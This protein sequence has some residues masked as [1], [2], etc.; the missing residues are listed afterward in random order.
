MVYRRHLPPVFA[1]FRDERRPVWEAHRQRTR[2]LQAAL[3]YAKRGWPVFPCRPRGKEPLTARGFKDATADPASIQLF[4]S[5]WPDANI[6]IATGSASRLLVV[7]VDPRNNGNEQLAALEAR[8]GALPADYLVRTA[9]GG[10][11]FYF[12][13]PAD[14]TVACGVLAKGIDIKCEGGYV[15]APPSIHPSGHRYQF[16][17]NGSVPPSPDWQLEHLRQKAGAQ[18]HSSGGATISV[19]ELRVSDDIKRLIREGKPKGERSEAVFGAIR[20]MVKAGHC[21][22]EIISIMMNQQYGIS[23]KPRENGLAWLKGEVARARAKPDR[24]ADSATQ[25][26]DSASFSGGQSDGPSG[27]RDSA[28]S[29]GSGTHA[30]PTPPSGVF[31]LPNDHYP[32]PGAARRIFGVIAMTR[33]MF[34]RG[35]TVVELIETSHGKEL[36]LVTSTAFRSRLDNY[37]Y[38]V[39]AYVAV[40][41]G[42]ALRRRRCS[43]DTAKALL[44]TLEAQELLPRIEL[45]AAAPIIVEHDGVPEILGPGYHEQSRVFVIGGEMPYEVPLDEATESLRQLLVDY[46]FQHPGDAARALA[47]LITPALK[48]GRLLHGPTPVDVGEADQ[49]QAGKT[50]R[51]KLIRAIYREHAYPVTMREGGVG[52]LDESISQALLSGKPFVVIDNVRGLISSQFLESVITTPD[53][54]S[55]R[56]PHRGEVSLDARRV[57]FQLSSNGVE[58]TPDFAN[59]SSIVR[60]RKRPKGYQYREHTEG[61]LLSHLIANQSYYL[62]CI[63]AVAAEW[64][65][66]GKPR[67]AESRHDFREWAQALDWIVQNLFGAAALLDGHE[68][69]QERVSNPALSWLRQ[70]CLAANQAGK[71]GQDLSATDIFELCADECVE[72]PRRTGNGMR[73]DEGCKLVG[74]LLAKAFRQADGHL[75]V[76]DDYRVTRHI[77]TEHDEKQR[78]DRETKRYVIECASAPCAP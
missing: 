11:H 77:G 45:V 24:D 60:I 72:F 36:A 50:F 68:Q 40:K 9:D 31:V 73:P 3:S 22:D 74:Q 43:E 25:S 55:A 8:H 47:A 49:S 70:V 38:Q 12:R 39:S 48:V 4:W 27:E 62:G 16:E 61:D 46:D 37:G 33:T 29:D 6:A 66:R 13:L 32:F 10:R 64:I 18:A 14:A 41:N 69:A 57:T 15:I 1:W 75:L 44:A 35:S 7:D 42:I 65:R 19:D 52:S 71:C 2:M 59:R 30:A 53:C 28:R 23:A 51:H 34:V 63:F 78:K 17:R 76:L 58:T 56:V 20:A 26:H 67:T 5:K 21:D 54:V